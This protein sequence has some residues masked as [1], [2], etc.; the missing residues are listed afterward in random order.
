MGDIDTATAALRAIL[1]RQAVIEAER[2][3]LAELLRRTAPMM[4]TIRS[5]ADQVCRMLEG[6]SPATDSA[7]TAAQTQQARPVQD[8][9][10]LNATVLALPVQASPIQAAPVQAPAVQA[11]P[12][13]TPP[14]VQA[15]EPAKKPGFWSKFGRVALKTITV[16]ATAAVG[17]GGL[18]A[19][20]PAVIGATVSPEAAA[21]VGAIAAAIA[22]GSAVH[23]EKPK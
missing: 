23:V 22:A 2:V 16:A 5:E 1:E 10:A 18:G 19:V 7:P 20:V 17:G 13:P 9:V 3:R 21:T 15:A 8:A 11:A 12:I 6:E 4:A 14:A